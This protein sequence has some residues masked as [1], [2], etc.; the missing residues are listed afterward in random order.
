MTDD[1]TKF[2]RANEQA[3]EAWLDEQHATR[4]HA[5]APTLS[6]AAQTSGWDAGVEWLLKMV[7]GSE[8]PWANVRVGAGFSTKDLCEQCRD[9]SMPYGTCHKCGRKWG[10]CAERS[11][12]EEIADLRKRVV[13][14]ES[15]H[16]CPCGCGGEGKH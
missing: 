12:E 9:P 11:L 14:L 4:S 8:N 5:F 7:T 10:G 6:R 1:E 13:K 16:K 15:A 3:R 2:R